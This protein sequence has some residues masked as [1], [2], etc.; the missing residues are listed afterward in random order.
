MPLRPPADTLSARLVILSGGQSGVDRAAL[1]AA[2]NAGVAV[3]GW[4]PG[5]RWAEDGPISSC[6]P[7]RETPGVDPADRTRRNVA[8]AD[9][10]LVLAP[11]PV[12]GGTALA[13]AHARALGR[14]VCIVDPALE[15]AAGRVVTWMASL[16]P[17]LL[18]LN[19]A[20]PRES[21][22]P[23]VYAL[24]RSFLEVVIHAL[25]REDA[26]RNPTRRS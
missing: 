24:A 4:C 17:S 22:M 19:V 20:G 11:G 26:T 7:L 9:A 23:G 3:G 18:V 13:V 25:Q 14:P 15:V 8:D 21:E 16:C 10:L 6:Y 12:G 1:D 5:G 2:L